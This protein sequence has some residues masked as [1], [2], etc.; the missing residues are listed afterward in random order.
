MKKILPVII[1]LLIAAYSQPAYA[2]PSLLSNEMMSFGSTMT[3]K[4]VT[5]YA[6]IDTTIRGAG[7][8]WNFAGLTLAGTPDYIVTALNPASTPYG[9]SFPS[10]N[11]AY[12]EYSAGNTDYSYYNLSASQ[13]SRVGSYRTSINI[14]TDPQVEYVFPLAMGVVNYDTW[15]NTSSSTGGTYDLECL[16]YGTL[17][18]PGI[19]Y[20]N[21][22]M[23]RVHAVEWILDFYVYFWY[24]SDNGKIL[25]QYI[26]GDGFIIP[27]AAQYLA[28]STTVV[29]E[30][31]IFDKALFNN[32]VSDRLNLQFTSKIT[33][34]VN[35]TITNSMGQTVLS[36]TLSTAEGNRESLEID[37]SHLSSGLYFFTAISGKNDGSIYSIKLIKQ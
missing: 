10:S 26:V 31:P 30:T 4:E 15:S 1:Y 7:V 8:T 18:L 13:L 22:L 23:V 9:S 2:Q 16:G 17:N 6:L 29:N 21:A 3:L 14:Y 20:Q 5:N 33:G 19:T 36:N 11:F 25:L 24:S 12:S 32:P 37:M 28:S 27:D 34:D 35:Y